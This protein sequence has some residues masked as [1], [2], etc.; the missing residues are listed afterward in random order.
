V[1]L[2]RKFLVYC[3]KIEPVVEVVEV[4]VVEVEQELGSPDK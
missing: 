1:D 3:R 2:A 4:A